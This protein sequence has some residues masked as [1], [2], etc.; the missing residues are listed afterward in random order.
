M[1][2]KSQKRHYDGSFSMT[3]SGIHQELDRYVIGQEN[4]KKVLFVAVYNHNKR[5][6]NRTGLSK[7]SNILLAGPSGCGKTLL[8]G[9]LEKMLD[10]PFVVVDTTGFTE[11]GYVGDDVE[12]CL[13]RLIEVTNGDIGLAQKGI[14]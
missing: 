6:S 4:A 14:V 10:V 11:T 5:L 8:A 2:N 13:Q 7:K 9:T 12:V 3:P 1:E